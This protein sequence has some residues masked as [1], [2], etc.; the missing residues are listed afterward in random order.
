MQSEQKTLSQGNLFGYLESGK[1][2]RQKAA[3]GGT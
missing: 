1:V 2:T 3:K